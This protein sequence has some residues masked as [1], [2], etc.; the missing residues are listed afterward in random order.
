MADIYVVAFGDDDERARRAAE[1]DAEFARLSAR[2]AEHLAVHAGLDDSVASRVIAV[3]FDQRDKDGQQCRCSCHPRL[4]ASHGD[5]L[6]CRC[7]WDEDRRADEAAK[8]TEFWDSEPYAD[9]REEH[10]REEA[11]IGRASCRE[12]V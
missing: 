12:R 2:Y 5:G 11:E 7:T 8:M 1:Q 9:L 6:D 10:K 3:L 4:S